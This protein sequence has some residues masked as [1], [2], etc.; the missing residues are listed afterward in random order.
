MASIAIWQSLPEGKPPISYG[1]PMVFSWFSYG[2]LSSGLK[3][4][5]D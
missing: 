5:V 1:F 3:K 4:M 2:L